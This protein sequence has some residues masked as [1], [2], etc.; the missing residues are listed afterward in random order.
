MWA[1]IDRIATRICIFG[2]Q[3]TER[4]RIAFKEGPLDAAK[5]DLD[6]SGHREK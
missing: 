4:P 6:Q 1:F 5:F 2:I 3:S